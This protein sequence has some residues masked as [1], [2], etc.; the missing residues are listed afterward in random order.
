[1]E[2]TKV[3]YK[4]RIGQVFVYL[5][6]QFRMFIFQN[7]W[8]VLPMAAIIAG[9][10]SMAVGNGLFLTMEGT[11]QGAL[12][13]ACVGMWNGCFNSIQVI[14]RERQII[15]REH[16]AGLHITSYVAAHLIYQ[17]CL[18]SAQTLITIMVCSYT[19]M[20]YPAEGVVS[21]SFRAE[22]FISLLLVTYAADVMALMVSAIV[23]STTSAMTV[24]PFMLIVQLVFA[25]FLS[26]PAKLRDVSDLMI[27]KWGMK[28]FCVLGRYNELPAVV[29]W[30]RLRSAGN[31]ELI[32]GVT[33]ASALDIVE[34]AGLKEQ[35]QKRL[36]QAAM[37]AEYNA[38][39]E[40]LFSSW[41]HLLVFIVIFA[42]LT[43]VFLEFIDKDKR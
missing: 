26:L 7:D 21:E 12:A 34:E 19:G 22:M 38:T 5:G 29:I 32:P 37:N 9:M 35:F 17:L 20:H 31:T 43:V 23:R 3:K 11:L 28:A 42:V 6:K 25:G 33:V 30:N 4:G 27:T 13:L 24:M 18:C 10:V 15:K 16:R 1:M 2:N 41:G 40:N 8:K 36:A 14:C 39:A